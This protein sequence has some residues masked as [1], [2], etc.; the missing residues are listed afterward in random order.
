MLDHRDPGLCAGRYAAAVFVA[1]GRVAVMRLPDLGRSFST[2][3]PV[4]AEPRDIDWGP[5]ARPKI[6]VDRDGRVVVAFAYFKDRAFNADVV[7]SRS[8]DG[9]ASF[10][11]PLPITANRESQRFEALALDQ[12]GARVRGLARQTKS[13][14][15]EGTQRG[16]CRRRPG[17]RLVERSRHR[18]FSDAR[19]AEDNTCECCRLGIAFAGPGR[20]VVLFRNVFDGTVRDHAITTFADPVTPGPEY[21]VSVDDWEIDAC[22]HQGPSLAIS[23]AGTYHAVWSTSGRI[24]KACSM[25][26]RIDGGASFSEPMRIGCPTAVRRALTCWRCP[27]CFGSPGKSSMARRPPSDVMASHDDGRTWSPPAIVAGTSLRHPTIRSWSP[28]RTGLSVLADQGRRLS[29]HPLGEPQMKKWLTLAILI[30]ALAAA[31]GGSAAVD[32]LHPF[33]AGQL[34]ANPCGS[35]RPAHGGAFLGSDLR[36]LP[37]RDAVA[38]QVPAAAARSQSGDDRRRLRAQRS[39][40]RFRALAQTGLAGVENWIFSDDFAERLRYE[41]D[42]QW[43]GDIPRTLLITK[44]GAVT[45][46]EGVADVEKLRAWLDRQAAQAR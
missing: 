24:R 18:R 21:R 3:I 29:P 28:T 17:L 7:Y 37:G 35:C 15:C 26:A 13:C 8:I 41:I 33:L 32:E 4:N 12:D 1:A 14:A 44:D 30:M 38:G 6:V 42:P 40:R 46:I 43:Q 36:T 22:P 23:A 20:P 2:P 39:A 31:T 34:E 10:A 27:A 45:T 5:D 11:P 9:G 25:P 19:I 16:L